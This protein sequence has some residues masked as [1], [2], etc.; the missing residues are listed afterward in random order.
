MQTRCFFLRDHWTYEGLADL[1][2]AF[3]ERYRFGDQLFFHHIINVFMDHDT[4]NA[5]ARLAGLVEGTK[6]DTIDSVV[7]IFGVRVYYN[8][9][10]AP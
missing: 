1:R 6:D 4:L 10:V 2:I 9:G 3:D 5:D 8:S 7:Q